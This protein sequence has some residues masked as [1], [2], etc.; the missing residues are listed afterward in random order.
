MLRKND[1]CFFEWASELLAVA[2][3]LP[4]RC[5]IVTRLH[6]FELYEWAPKVN[7]EVVDSV[8][9]VSQAMRS[10]FVELYPEQSHKTEVI[11]NGVRLDIFQPAPAMEFSFRLGMLCNIVPI[12]RIYEVVL[13]LGEL[14]ALGY[15]ATLH[16]GGEPKDDIRYA[17]S[18]YRLVEELNLQDSVKFDGYIDDPAAWLQEIDIFISNSYWEGQQVALL[19][20][21]ASSCYCLS[22]FWS[23][24]EEILPPEN[25][26]ITETQLKDLII[27]YADLKDFEKVTLQQQ[28]RNITVSKFDIEG[29]KRELQM[30]IKR[31]AAD[32]KA[33]SLS[34]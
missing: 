20:A 18:I 30:V 8:V 11:Y 29:T 28:L 26:Y 9:F 34:K 16:I 1:V 32:G 6:S 12:K 3:H 23:G 10:R 19:E 5:K 31:V 17:Q 25:I 7:W 4:K 14:R 33:D 15:P 2:S 13:V 27:Q 22:H 24:V 21:M